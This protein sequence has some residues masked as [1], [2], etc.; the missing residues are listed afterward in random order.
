M[1]RDRLISTVDTEARRGH[2]SRART[3]DGYKSH[4]AVDPDDELITAVSVTAA[5]A[6]DRE[7]LDELLGQ[8][9][10][11]AAAGDAASGGGESAADCEPAA[12]KRAADAAD[13]ADQSQ[14][15]CGGEAGSKDFEVYGDSAYADGPTLEEQTRRGHDMRTK[16]PPVRNAN[17]FSKDRFSIDLATGTVTC[18]A[19][20]TVAIRAGRRHRVARFGEDP[21]RRHQPRPP[22][23]PGPAPGNHR[24][25]H[26]LT[27]SPT[28]HPGV[29]FHMPSQLSS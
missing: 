20:H 28:T 24:L 9:H 19:E 3:F 18:P 2:K 17:G 27:A 4:L 23:H 15:S 22:G 8:P 13:S 7:V 29:N 21:S 11:G 25:G 14:G 6:A 5:N 12:K 10:T 16:V 1:A 26:R